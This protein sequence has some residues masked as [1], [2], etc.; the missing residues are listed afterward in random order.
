MLWSVFVLLAFVHSQVLS[1]VD[2]FALA[3]CV[4]QLHD[5]MHDDSVRGLGL[6]CLVSFVRCQMGGFSVGFAVF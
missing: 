5:Q 2:C 6:G 4:V 3:L 1:D